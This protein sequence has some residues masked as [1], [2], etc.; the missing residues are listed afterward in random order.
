MMFSDPNPSGCWCWLW[1]IG[2]SRGFGRASAK[3]LLMSA[4]SIRRAAFT[5]LLLAV[6]AVA[7]RSGT[8]QSTA[9]AP[10][11][12]KYLVPAPEIVR[13]FDALPLPQVIVSPSRQ[14]LALT[15]RK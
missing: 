1:V 6:A 7:T 5:V 14:V 9:S 4:R 8:A 2:R 12:S 15:M 10:D 11:V 13:T 3:E